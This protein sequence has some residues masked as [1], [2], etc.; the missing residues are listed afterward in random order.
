[1][2]NIETGEASLLWAIRFIKLAREVST[3]SKDP[4]TKVGAVI[5]DGRLPVSFGYNGFPRGVA[6]TPERLNDREQKYGLTVHAEINAIINARGSVRGADLYLW[7]F[8]PCSD[9]A[10]VVV[11][12]GIRN[13]ITVRNDNERWVE[14]F[15]RTRTLFEEAGVRLIELDS[16]GVPD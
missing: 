10:K 7:P 15:K 12:A 11:N 2:S 9:C 4:S 13:V 14:S 6:D 5:M 8:M 16:P 3:W 1:M